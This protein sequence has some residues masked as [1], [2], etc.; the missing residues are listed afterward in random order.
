[1]FFHIVVVWGIAVSFNHARQDAKTVTTFVIVEIL[2]AVAL[3]AFL[4]A[5]VACFAVVLEFITIGHLDMRTLIPRFIGMVKFEQ[6]LKFD[7][8]V[9]DDIFYYPLKKKEGR[10]DKGCWFSVDKSP[11][12][13][14]LA[15]IIGTAFN[16]VISY[17]VDLTLVCS[18]A[19][20]L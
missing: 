8:W 12:T 9:I 2:V 18:P 16:L 7:Y 4:C 13:W 1:M 14:F 6:G 19:G 20:V 17:F 11:A 3:P 15:I 5:S 10:S